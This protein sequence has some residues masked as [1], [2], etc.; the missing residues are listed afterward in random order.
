MRMILYHDDTLDLNLESLCDG[1]NRHSRGVKFVG[2][3][4]PAL[5][6]DDLISARTSY[7]TLELPD[8]VKF[9][10]HDLVMIAT[11]KRYDNNY[12]YEFV[13]NVGIFSFSAWETLTDLPEIN[14]LMYFVCQMLSDN[15][16]TGESHEATTGCINDFLWDKTGIDLGMKS[17]SLCTVCNKQFETSKR[18]SKEM[19]V[20]GTLEAILEQLG[21]ASR[22]GM[23]ILDFWGTGRSGG[24]NLE[25]GR[26]DGTFDVF[27]CHNSRDKDAI[28]ELN[29]IL[30]G[31]E[32]RTWLDEEQ[33]RPGI[34]WQ[35]ELE[36][37][38]QSINTVL[39]AVGASGTGPWQDVEIR[40]FLGEFVRRKCPVIPVVLPDC[41]EIPKLPLFLSQFTWVDLRKQKP[42]PIKLL[43]WGITGR[44]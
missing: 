7:K 10:G 12:F 14:G 28:R 5:I 20:F 43:L 41:E 6:R 35:D 25:N 34:L 18:S 29:S 19:E 42:D 2:Q 27:L 40:A 17:A 3:N 39:V 33:L 8:N 24:D 9:G 37:Q 4:Q 44:K 16:P 22:K 13:G 23:S 38:I 32:I 1:L 30:K 21:R 26:N 11:K 15:L 31:H 36:A